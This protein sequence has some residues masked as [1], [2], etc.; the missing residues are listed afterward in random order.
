[1]TILLA[2]IPASLVLGGL[3]LAAFFRTPRRLRHGHFDRA[4]KLL[5]VE[6]PYKQRQCGI[7]NGKIKSK[8]I[9]ACTEQAWNH[10]GRAINDIAC[11]HGPGAGASNSF[12][13]FYPI[14]RPVPSDKT[15]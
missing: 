15:R 13:N 8:I 4:P 12:L 7:D 9:H 2:T 6:A 1:M 14:V 10:G 5:V 11:G 3:G